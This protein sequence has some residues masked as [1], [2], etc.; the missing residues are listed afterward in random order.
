MTAKH[1]KRLERFRKTL[2]ND[3]SRIFFVRARA[4]SYAK[5]IK[6]FESDLALGGFMYRL[7][8]RILI[9]REVQFGV[10]EESI[11]GGGNIRWANRNIRQK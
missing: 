4:K 6:L 7:L 9:E 2:Q 11:G 10:Q 1:L 8:E 3:Q 5:A